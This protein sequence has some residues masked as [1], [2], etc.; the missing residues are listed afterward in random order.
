[1]GKI[2]LICIAWFI[3]SQIFDTVFVLPKVEDWI[4]TVLSRR[5]RMTAFK[6]GLAIEQESGGSCEMV[7]TGMAYHYKEYSDR[8]PNGSEFLAEAEKEAKSQHLGLWR[9]R[10]P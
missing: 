9:K 3:G 4:L 10:E 7:R 8:C 2:L 5:G 6:I 1:M